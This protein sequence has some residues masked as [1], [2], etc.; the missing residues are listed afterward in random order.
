MLLEEN[1]KNTVAPKGDEAVIEATL[2]P[3][4]IYAIALESYIELEEAYGDMQVQQCATEFTMFKEDGGIDVKKSAEKYAGKAKAWFQ[5][6][7]NAIKA[8]WNKVVTQLRAWFTNSEK[9]YAANKEAITKGAGL[10]KGFKGYKYGDILQ[11]ASD[12]RTL[13]DAAASQINSA[14][15]SDK[16]DVAASL[17]MVRSHIAG[18]SDAGAFKA[19][20]L[21][22][23]RGDKVVELSA[24]DFTFSDLGIA[25]NINKAIAI[26][27]KSSDLFMKKVMNQVDAADKGESNE[28]KIAFLKGITGIFHTAMATCATLMAASLNQTKHFAVAAARV[29][30]K[31]GPEEPKKAPKADDGS[32]AEG[33]EGALEGDDAIFG[34]GVSFEDYLKEA[35]IE[36][37]A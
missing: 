21:K 25:S 31:K 18:E 29:A 28:K 13:S 19:N 22:K 16:V 32:V 17:G 1:A 9:F 11:I 10:V 3:S 6:V 30:P 24:K 5:K 36:L 26:S 7:W 34:E 14:F 12:V 35:G 4:G 37:M 15:K 8:F 23:Y 33:A 2:D 27:A 20:I